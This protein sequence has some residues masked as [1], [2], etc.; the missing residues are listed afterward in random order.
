MQTVTV[1][2]LAN[3]P[4]VFAIPHREVCVKIGRCL[5]SRNGGE[6]AFHC[7]AGKPNREVPGVWMLSSFIKE[8]A[9]KGKIKIV[10]NVAPMTPVNVE[11]KEPA[12]KK[13]KGKRGG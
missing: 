6:I 5:C 4:M 8:A 2:N 11:E 13:R 3:K 7:M 10:P 12:R 9:N 1:Y